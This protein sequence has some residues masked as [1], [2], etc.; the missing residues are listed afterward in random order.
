M[1]L[2]QGNSTDAH[3]E[4]EKAMTIVANMDGA[5]EA[6]GASGS[7]AQAPV[8]PNPVPIVPSP[9]N[10]SG[11]EAAYNKHAKEDNISPDS[12]DAMLERIK[13][14]CQQNPPRGFLSQQLRAAQ[15]YADFRIQV[16][17]AGLICANF[18][19]N[20]AEKQFDPDREF[21]LPFW[22]AADFFYNVVF[23]LELILNMYGFWFVV[24]WTSAWNW[25]D[26]VV[27]SLG[28]LD[29]LQVPLPGEL[30]LLRMMRAFRVFR[31][32]KRVKSLNKIAV[33]ILR[34]VP[35]VLN[36]FLIMIIVMSI[37]AM[38]SVQFYRNKGYIKD[39]DGETPLVV[40]GSFVCMEKFLTSRGNCFG[41][42]Y[43]GS[44]SKACY[45]LFQILTGESWSEAIVRL[46]LIEDDGFVSNM[47]S[48][49]FFISFFLMNAV[50]L[51]NVVVAVLLDK[52]A[53]EDEED[54]PEEKDDQDS[55]LIDSLDQSGGRNPAGAADDGACRG[56][57][58]ADQGLDSKV[59]RSDME[60]LRCQI[61]ELESS[62]QQQ[63][64]VLSGTLQQVL[65]V[66]N[67]RNAS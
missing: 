30:S 37:Y 22:E 66:V 20:I 52:M 48:A 1:A 58:G 28:V 44:Y 62:M 2:I 56:K 61:S 67:A 45:S 40:K 15:L 63:L 55:M 26:V 17:V 36:A 57:D 65:H 6:G 10:S 8:S 23:L 39:V 42:E 34:S 51:I 60:A 33:S 9:E 5:G 49:F 35:G 3:R 38:L 19:T 46:I 13:A 27:V 21:Y 47:G 59:M 24:F 29:M 12:Q 53:N 32:F 14:K 4:D 16:F 54:Q 18:G 64:S 11:N 25:F 43:F 41:R 50:V 31:L 7:A